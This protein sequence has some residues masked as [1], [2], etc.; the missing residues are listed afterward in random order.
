[1]SSAPSNSDP[2]RSFDR[3]DPRL[4][5]WIWQSR[6]KSLHD[7]QARAIPLLLAGEQD[8]ILAAATA[9]GKTEAAF[10]PIL[11][12]LAQSPE[13]IATVAYISPLK[14][15]INDQFDRLAEIAGQVELPVTPWHGDISQ[16]P[17]SRYLQNPR[18]CLLI[19]PESLEA[20][21]V[22]Q[23]H[24]VGGVFEHLRFVVI[25]EL[26]SFMGTERG[27]QLQSLLHRVEDAVGRRICRIGLSATLGDMQAAA[28][29]LRPGDAAKVAL[30]VSSESRQELRV[31]VRGIEEVPGSPDGTAD[32]SEHS[33]RS[34]VVKDLFVELR[35]QNHLV[36]PNSRSEVEFYSDQLRRMC[37]N[38]RVPNEFWPHH[39]SLSREIREETEAALK[40]HERP[41]TAI[42]TSTLELGID[43][44]SV[45]SVAQV[46]PPPSV[47]SLRQRL[48]RS[49]RR[50]NEPAILRG[51]AIEHALGPDSGTS[52]ML[53]EGLVQTTAM[54]LLLAQKWCEPVDTGAIH[55][56]TLVQQ[57]LSCLAQRGGMTARAAW[58]L[59]CANGP[60]SPVDQ[61]M[62]IS[63]LAELGRRELVMQDPNGPLM[64]A[65][66][67]ERAV[68]HYTFC[69]AF[70]TPEEYRVVAEGRTLGSL[71]IARP[72]LP[73][74]YI[75][76]A[77]RRWCVLSCSPE[78]L[79]ILVEPARAGAP[80]SFLGG[81][82]GEVNCRVR[83]E[84]RKILDESAIVPFL[85]QCARKLL[86]EARDNFGR[87]CLH[88][89]WIRQS[90]SDVELYPW[91]GDKVHNTLSLLLKSRDLQA[92]NE[93]IVLRV[94]RT[95]KA[96]VFGALQGLSAH[97]CP[98]ATSLA[99]CVP[100]KI[101]EKWDFVLPE[102][103]LAASY[104]SK[105]LDVP[106]AR[107]WIQEVVKGQTGNDPQR[108]AVF[109][110]GVSSGI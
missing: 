9:Q 101:R 104:A 22:R 64:L 44:G 45:T 77:S 102:P 72:L 53:R 109:Q 29:F 59:L 48:G 38:E 14:A 6:W 75:V 23:G 54:V 35:G 21:F 46:R 100:N 13:L 107:E 50:E 31:L 43:I 98:T 26:H 17:K 87:L 25:D 90:G 36:F 10:L 74:T 41:A 110:S 5:R 20:L 71:P 49:G 40:Q 106:A 34:A 51:Y 63:L 91:R 93:G 56:S 42:C 4:Q 83:H 108:S 2:A 33:G 82:G 81:D 1:M 68:E 78:D 99:E 89:T 65:P 27:K 39:G 66:K 103:L 70:A 69:A 19:T 61:R 97:E 3:L 18:G 96:T 30:I 8:V 32:E 67:G 62:F 80:P 52:D 15:L 60:F 84:M 37:E 58:T 16:S 73:G 85:D 94:A 105:A 88:D 95:D 24:S 57:L 86:Q 12:N 28:M 7:V 11:S 55:A 76:F 47:A 92:T 79:L